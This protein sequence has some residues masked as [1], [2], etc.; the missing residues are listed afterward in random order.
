MIE[1]KKALPEQLDRLIEIEQMVFPPEEAAVKETFAYRM[2]KYPYWFRSAK[3]GDEIVGYICGIC[4]K[5]MAGNINYVLVL[6]IINLVM[7]S[8]DIL[9]YVRNRKLDMDGAAQ[10]NF[11]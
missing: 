2:E 7:V 8:T 11:A 4:S 5:F 1:I 9:L 3:I 6:Y 10:E